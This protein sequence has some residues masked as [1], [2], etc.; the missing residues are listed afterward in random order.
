MDQ[1]IVPHSEPSIAPTNATPMNGT[2]KRE[3]EDDD[4]D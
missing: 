4:V 2:S 3:K 1:L